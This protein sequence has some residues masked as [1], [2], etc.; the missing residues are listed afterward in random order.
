M[1]SSKQF[2]QNTIPSEVTKNLFIND[3]QLEHFAI[4]L[5]FP[6]WEFKLE[7]YLI[8][9]KCWVFSQRKSSFI[10]WFLSSFQYKLCHFTSVSSMLNSSFEFYW[11]IY[12]MRFSISVSYFYSISNY[13]QYSLCYLYDFYSFN[14]SK[15][16]FSLSLSWSFNLWFSSQSLTL[17]NSS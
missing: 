2:L 14:S 1:S 9:A 5:N 8:F 4:V 11:L 3:E 10:F 6:I 7:I 16:F 17:S 12:D 15:Y 13:F